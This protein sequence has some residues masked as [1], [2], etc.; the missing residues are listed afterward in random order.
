MRKSVGSITGVSNSV[1]AKREQAKRPTRRIQLI[2]VSVF[3]FLIVP[4]MA[5]SFLVVKQGNLSFVLTAVATILRDLALVSLIFFFLWR[6]S[7]LVD[8]IGWTSRNIREEIALGL[9]LF[10]PLFY[11]MILL[12][13]ALQAIGLSAPSAPLPSFLAA[14]GIAQSLLASLLVIV[15]AAAEE[16]IRTSRRSGSALGNYFLAGA[17][18]RGIGRRD[19]RRRDGTILS[20]GLPVATKP[21]CAYGDALPP[22]LHRHC[23]AAAA[24]HEV[25]V[26]GLDEEGCRVRIFGAF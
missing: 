23:R 18:L 20:A 24:W 22:G 2:E 17:W 19:N 1:G 16:T 12:E 10:V 4:S 26:M 3:L 5:L 11:G 15:V 25:I 9:W 7:E 8:S 13:Q 6:N 14:K 21:G